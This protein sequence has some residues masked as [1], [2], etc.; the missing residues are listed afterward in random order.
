MVEKCSDTGWVVGRVRGEDGVFFIVGEGGVEGVVGVVVMVGGSGVVGELGDEV[1]GLLE[2][3]GDGAVVVLL[4]WLEVGCC[5]GGEGIGFE[6]WF[7]HCGVVECWGDCG[8]GIIV[9]MDKLN[10][11]GC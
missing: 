3:K 2:F 6:V 7:G 5:R 8:V 11:Q 4:L 9:V 10:G 1:T